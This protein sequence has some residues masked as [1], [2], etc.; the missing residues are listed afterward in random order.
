MDVSR[1]SCNAFE[2]ARG[3][4]PFA[5][6]HDSRGYAVVIRAHV[7]DKSTGLPLANATVEI[8]VSGPESQVFSAG[9]SDN[10]GLAEVTWQTTAPRKKGGGGTTPGSYTAAVT[11]VTASGYTWDGVMTSTSFSI[12]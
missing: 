11:N 4:G 2:K 6:S 1:R 3:G 12:Q 8:S 7:V 10:A 5:F 9:P